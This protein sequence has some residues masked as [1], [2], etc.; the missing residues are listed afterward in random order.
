MCG[1]GLFRCVEA[2]WRRWL[3][4]KAKELEDKFEAGEEILAYLDLST[5]R[6]PVQ[7]HKRVNVDFPVW[8]D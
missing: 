5:A 1:S 4:M 7:E 2:G 6:R 8:I 3:C